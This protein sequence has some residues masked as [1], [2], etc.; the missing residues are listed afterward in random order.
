MYAHL[1]RGAVIIFIVIMFMLAVR[2]QIN[3]IQMHDNWPKTRIHDI[4]IYVF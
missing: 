2:A 1:I 3:K 4:M